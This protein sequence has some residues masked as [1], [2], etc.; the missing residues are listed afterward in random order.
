[1]LD[2]LLDCGQHLPILT[3]VLGW[4][5]PATWLRLQRTRRAFLAALCEDRLKELAHVQSLNHTSFFEAVDEALKDHPNIDVFPLL[6]CTGSESIAPELLLDS[7]VDSA[8]V[9]EMPCPHR[10]DMPSETR[11]IRVCEVALIASL[12]GFDINESQDLTSVTP[13]MRAAEESDLQLC[14]LLLTRRADANACTIGGA[15]PLSLALDPCCMHCMTQSRRGCQ[16]PR[17]AVARLLLSWTSTGLPEAFA[18]T[19]RLALQDAAWLPVIADFVG[20]KNLPIN[21]EL[22]GPDGRL[23]TALSVALERRV[24]PIEA[25]PRHRSAVVA[26]LL[27]LRAEVDRR[28]SYSAWWGGEA[29]NLL[30]FA[31]LNQC[32]LETVEL[33]RAASAAN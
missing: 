18:A 14:Q 11:T 22:L 31:A 7:N 23:G 21:T 10:G 27:A 29:G 19:V 24:R 25:P 2:A 12:T 9:V 13:L 3:I 28:S 15:T 20:A 5:P 26:A 16:C 30:D 17:L 1:M 8:H 6:E 32:D 33:L 4:V